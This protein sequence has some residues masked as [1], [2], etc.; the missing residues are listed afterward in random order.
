MPQD[1]CGLLQR[2]PEMAQAVQAHL[3]YVAEAVKSHASGTQYVNFLNLAGASPE[4]V[5]ASYSPEDWER[6][7]A[8]KD[9]RDLENLFHFDRNIPPSSAG[10]VAAPKNN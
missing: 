7:V 1:V 5:R 3:A 6:V 8:L 10:E 4:R 9:R 2:S